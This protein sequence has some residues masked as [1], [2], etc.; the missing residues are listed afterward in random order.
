MQSGSTHLGLIG[1][2]FLRR[3]DV[4]LFGE[5]GADEQPSK[6]MQSIRASLRLRCGSM[7]VG[8]F[9]LG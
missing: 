2:D 1:W 9:N 6:D 8:C 3:G 7:I 5:V 4:G